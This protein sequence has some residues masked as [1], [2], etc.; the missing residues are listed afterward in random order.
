MLARLRYHRCMPRLIDHDQRRSEIAQAVWRIALRD[1]VGAV[2]LRSVADEAR[3]ALGSVRHIF[4]TKDDLLLYAMEHVLEGA[5]G[6]IRPHLENADAL[7]S[8]TAALQELLPLDD[9]REVE[10]R[11]HLALMGEAPGH[12]GLTELAVTADEAILQLCRRLLHRLQSEG[13]MSAQ[14]D[15]DAEAVRLHALVDGLALHAI[16]RPQLRGEL[17]GQVRYQLRE[18]AG[19]PVDA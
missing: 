14:R 13:R 17:T 12:P 8:A 10:M 19:P 6:R 18:L 15:V 16:T 11:V 7:E 9:E 3:L 4:A 1:G 2:S 5:A